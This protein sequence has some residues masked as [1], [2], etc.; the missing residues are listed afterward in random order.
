MLTGEAATEDE[1]GGQRQ[2]LE[3]RG[4]EEH[5]G[6]GPGINLTR[7]MAEVGSCGRR[8]RRMSRMMPEQGMRRSNR[9]AGEA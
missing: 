3:A 9:D 8:A 7:K 1:H 5:L 4:V 2:E 6:V